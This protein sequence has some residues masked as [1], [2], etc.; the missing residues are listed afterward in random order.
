MPNSIIC[1]ILVK[2]FAK[3]S[4]K[5]DLPVKFFKCET[6]EENEALNLQMLEKEALIY[7]LQFH[8]IQNGC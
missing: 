8:Y 1:E 6:N 3:G 7:F 4:F 5:W 2:I